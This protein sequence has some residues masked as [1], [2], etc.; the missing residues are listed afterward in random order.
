[1]Q[2]D[3]VLVGRFPELGKKGSELSRGQQAFNLAACRAC[4]RRI[5]DGLQGGKVSW[6]C[7]GYP[8]ASMP[9]TCGGRS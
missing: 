8:N 2:R 9:A 4:R 5:A 3:P 1:M 7:R 6:A